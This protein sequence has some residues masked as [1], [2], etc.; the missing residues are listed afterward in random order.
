MRKVIILSG[1]SGSGKS[2]RAAALQQ[3]VEGS[4]V[5]SADQYFT[6]STGYFF[7]ASKLSE[8]H[9]SC[10]RS[11]VEACQ[12]GAPLV[13]VDNTNTRTEEISPYY[14]GAQ[15]FG[16]TP[17]IQTVQC[18]GLA[19]LQRM[20][21]RNVHGVPFETVELQHRRILARRLPS[22]WPHVLIDPVW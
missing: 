20:A 6:S 1:V 17:A 3:E 13:V 4:V 2:T 21:E 11:F 7:N 18:R 16:Y 22:H 14:L 12:Q 5:V 8:A 19:D 10:F 15:A 9:A